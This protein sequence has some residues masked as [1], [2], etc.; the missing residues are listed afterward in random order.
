MNYI[1][2]YEFQRII[3]LCCQSRGEI[4]AKRNSLIGIV[5]IVLVFGMAFIGCDNATNE[6]PPAPTLFIN[7]TTVAINDG[8]VASPA[9]VTVTG[10]AGG[11]VTYSRGTLPGAV[12]I[13]VTATT[14]TLTGTRPSDDVEPITGTHNVTITRGQATA[15]LEVTVN[16]TT[17][18]TPPIPYITLNPT[19]VAINDGNVDIP[20]TVA[21][22]GTAEGVVTY[23]RGTLPEAV[24]INVTGTTITLTGT[25]P[26][27]DVEP[28]TGT[29]NVTIIRGEATATLEVTVNLT[30]TWTPAP[31]PVMLMWAEQ[32]PLSGATTTALYLRFNAPFTALEYTYVGLIYFGETPA[33][34]TGPAVWVPRMPGHDH[35]FEDHMIWRIPVTT[36]L[37]NTLVTVTVERYVGNYEV[38]MV[39]NLFIDHFPRNVAIL[40]VP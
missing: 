4:M 28:I 5:A 16:L 39:D 21:V 13:N 14:I 3:K 1:G 26:S 35:V 19:S 34:P 25:R 32:N 2:F 23:S 24:A 8:N 27:D 40:F 29:H 20:T 18:W 38:S 11:A 30:T 37:Q 7:P 33:T 36:H 10:T 17:T 22:T 15:T 31:T 9:T 6:V 12:A